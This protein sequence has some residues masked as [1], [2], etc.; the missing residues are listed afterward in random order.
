MVNSGIKWL[1]FNISAKP[2]VTKEKNQS[3]KQV[4][5]NGMSLL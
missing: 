5:I 4:I 1:S 3:G 2:H